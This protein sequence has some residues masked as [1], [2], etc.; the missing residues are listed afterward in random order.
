LKISPVPCKL[1]IEEALA[2]HA[3]TIQQ[4]NISIIQAIENVTI[5]GDRE[6][7]LS[8]VDNLISNAIKFTPQDGKIEVR[9]AR[10]GEAIS[11]QV[12]DTG[13]GVSPY[14][15]NRLF[16]PFYSGSATYDGL[17]SGSGLGLSI[18][19]EYVVAHGGSIALADSESGASF[20]VLLPL[21]AGE[22]A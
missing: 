6:K 10:N 7:L 22:A 8:V 4:K 17:V 2:S 15:R 16:E 18:V 12:A 5:N 14:D 3:L 1:L 9:L 21:V 11:L 13:P 20:K 19:K